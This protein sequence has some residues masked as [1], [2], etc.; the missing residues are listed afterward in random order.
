MGRDKDE[1]GG[2]AFNWGGGLIETLARPPPKKK[3]QL[4]QPPQTNPGTF[5][6]RMAV[7]FVFKDTWSPVNSGFTCV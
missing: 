7:V 6:V 3:A 2:Q 5:M 4:A 1:R